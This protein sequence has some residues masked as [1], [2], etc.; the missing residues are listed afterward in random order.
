MTGEPPIGNRLNKRCSSRGLLA[1]LAD[2]GLGSSVPSTPVV[3]IAGVASRFCT[4]SAGY[5][6][7]GAVAVWLMRVSRRHE[8]IA[9]FRRRKKFV[10]D[11]EEARTYLTCSQTN[12]RGCIGQLMVISGS[13]TMLPKNAPWRAWLESSNAGND[14]ARA[15]LQSCAWLAPWLG[16]HLHVKV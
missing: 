11:W 2:A 9:A 6:A 15:V 10:S 3:D 8:C 13:L 12:R 4:K 1:I 5:L 16:R 14:A 7:A